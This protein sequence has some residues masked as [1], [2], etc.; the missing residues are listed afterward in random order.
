MDEAMAHPI[1]VHLAGALASVA[2]MTYLD[3]SAGSASGSSRH[4]PPQ[5]DEVMRNRSALTVTG[6]L[7][8]ILDCISHLPLSRRA[9]VPMAVEHGIQA[10]VNLA[11]CDEAFVQI[12]EGSGAI[13]LAFDRLSLVADDSN[14]LVKV[15]RLVEILCHRSDRAKGTG[16]LSS[17]SD[18]SVH[19]QVAHC[20]GL[21]LLIR[22]AV[23]CE[24]NVFAISKAMKAVALVWM[25]PR[26]RTDILARPRTTGGTELS[27]G[28]TGSALADMIEGLEHLQLVLSQGFYFDESPKTIKEIGETSDRIDA[29]LTAMRGSASRGGP[30][31]SSRI[32]GRTL[33]GQGPRY[34]RHATDDDGLGSYYVEATAGSGRRGGGHRIDGSARRADVDTQHQAQIDAFS[35]PVRSPPNYQNRGSA[36]TASVSPAS[37]FQSESP[38]LHGGALGRHAYSGSRNR[39]FL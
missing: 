28:D 9:A 25:E 26:T 19:M 34:G 4:A 16:R 5:A 27:G 37:S 17:S 12:V 29:L 36:Y 31:G 33:R 38:S 2:E 14:L 20:Q 8:L 1:L 39:K 35:G 18:D 22:S 13:A 32:G 7:P 21:R 10:L 30:G 6:F 11:L 15:S 23:Q 3:R 24:R